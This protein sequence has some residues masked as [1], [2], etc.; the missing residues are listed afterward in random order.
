[1]SSFHYLHILPVFLKRTAVFE[2][3]SVNVFDNS[4]LN[5]VNLKYNTVKIFRF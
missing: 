3:Y 2:M 5:N 1:M 4:V